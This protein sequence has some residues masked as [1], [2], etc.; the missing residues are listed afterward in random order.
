V[1]WLLSIDI[2]I[3]QGALAGTAS[4]VRFGRLTRRQL[5]HSVCG[6]TLAL[7]IETSGRAAIAIFAEGATAPAS[8]DFVL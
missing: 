2:P 1:K 5:S 6:P 8:M 7:V 4:P 3:V